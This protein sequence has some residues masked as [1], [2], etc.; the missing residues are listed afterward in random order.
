MNFI[1]I[2]GNFVSIKDFER[3]V[4]FKVDSAEPFV[5]R[6][7]LTKLPPN[8]DV[9]NLIKADFSKCYNLT[10]INDGLKA[11]NINFNHCESLVKIGKNIKALSIYF[12]HCSN[13][14]E[15]PED[16][17]T[18]MI[19]LTGTQVDFLNLKYAE[20]TDLAIICDG[21]VFYSTKDFNLF[22]NSKRIV[23]NLK[24]K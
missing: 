20:E 6:S 1:K 3:L 9:V 5:A 16:L 11:A 21:K 18:T 2:N 14:K 15:I 22:K 10:E 24:K 23:K 7:D 12:D 17:R 19:S 8:L 13:L 4:N